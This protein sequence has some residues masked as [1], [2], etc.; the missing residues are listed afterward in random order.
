MHEDQALILVYRARAHQARAQYT[1]DKNLVNN[2]S[3]EVLFPL[4]SGNI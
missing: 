2:I 1:C 3:E 4:N